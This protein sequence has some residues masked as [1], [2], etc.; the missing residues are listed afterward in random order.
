MRLRLPV[1]VLMA[2]LSVLLVCIG[3]A[4]A[5]TQG[6]GAATP[7]ATAAAP[8]GPAAP[9]AQN[10]PAGPQ[11]AAP[12]AAATPNKGLTMGQAFLLKLKQGGNTII[13]LFLASVAGLAYAIERFVNLRARAFVPGGMAE[14]A[15]ELWRAG[16]FD[17]IEA[18]ADKS[19]ST[20]ARVLALIARHRHSSMADVSLM[21]GDVAARDLRRHTLKAYP[22]AIVATV[23]PLLGLFGTVIG[24]IQAFD[25]VAAAGSLGD[26]SL[27]GGSISKALITTAAGLTIAIPTLTCYHYFRNRTSQ[28]ALQL[29]E[30]V[31]ELINEWFASPV[32]SEPAPAEPA[33]SEVSADE[34]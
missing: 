6:A 11:G 22:L 30:E 1:L 5:Q 29:E 17:Q 3:A 14:Q 25:I 20:L 13:F 21:A 12:T 7:A 10:A 26:A 24:M 15:D 18:L 4:S 33:P 8:Q 23:S 16:K 31:S 32:G 34:D 27:L 28:F 9:V 2:L 19:N